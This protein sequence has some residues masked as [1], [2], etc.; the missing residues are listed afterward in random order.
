MLT[1]G[2]ADVIDGT[3]VT[4]ENPGAA[5]TTSAAPTPTLVPTASLSSLLLKRSEL[6]DIVGDTDMT[7]QQEINSPMPAEAVHLDPF[8]CRARALPA[9]E[10]LDLPSVQGIAGNVNRGARGMGVTQVVGVFTNRKD[11]ADSP[12]FVLGTWKVCK[13]GQVYTIDTGNGGSQHWTAGP[14]TGSNTRI[15]T[16]ATRQEPPPRTCHHIVTVQANVEVE[17]IVCGDGDTTAQAN[18]VVDR[19]LA[20]VPL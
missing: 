1:S 6:G 10:G 3:A 9:E 13:D 5:A 14:I 8:D 20:K 12:T 4:A 17:T 2:C 18:M 16:T 15:E 7:Q 11:A 19:I